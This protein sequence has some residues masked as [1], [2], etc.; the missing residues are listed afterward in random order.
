MFTKIIIF[1][2]KGRFS[3]TTTT[4]NLGW[5]LASLGKKVLLV[6]ADPQC[7]LSSLMLGDDFENYYSETQTQFQNIKD[8]IEVAFQGRIK[9]IQAVSCFSPA[10]NSNLFLLAGHANL[11]E[12]EVALSF[13]QI[14]NSVIG[15]Y[16]TLADLP[17]A[18]NEL[19]EKTATRYNIEF[20]LI[21]PSPGLSAINQNL[22]ISSDAFIIPTNLDHFSMMAINTLTTILPRWVN[23]VDRV[24]PFF[25]EATYPLANS[26]PKF[27]GGIIQLVN[28]KKGLDRDPMDEIRTLVRNEFAPEMAK[29]RMLF[30]TE[31][32][33]KVGI[34]D[35]FCL[36]E[37]AD[38]T[39]ASPVSETGPS[40]KGLAEYRNKFY[41]EF[42]GLANKIIGL[43]EYAKC[44]ESI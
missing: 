22:F 37:V 9:P 13:A 29:N 21:E 16:T 41:E 40:W 33:Q 42:K 4:Y 10:A 12:Y 11:S 32:Y 27:I 39:S 5:M 17:G 26:Q 25:A 7:H 38:Y 14:S 19:V 15:T 44:N 36:L 8:G 35:D 28:L 2:H 24:R 3:K 30:P 18:F 1:N 34:G 43:A 23:W 20:V 31:A 6:D